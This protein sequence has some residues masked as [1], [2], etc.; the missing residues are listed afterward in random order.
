MK[1]TEVF[2]DIETVPLSIRPYLK[3][4][5]IYDSSC[6]EH[7]KTFVV[8]GQEHAFLKISSKGTLER[9]YQMTDFLHSHHVALKV[10][11][12]DSDQDNNY[13]LSEALHGEDGTE[14]QYINNP[15]K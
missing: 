8:K 3:G 1:K 10:I 14:R 4:A 2:F 13:L 9:E 6:S 15:R 11:A 12:Y 7:A 5:A